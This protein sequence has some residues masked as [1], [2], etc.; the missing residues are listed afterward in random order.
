[1]AKVL[2][3][4]AGITLHTLASTEVECEYKEY[5]FPSFMM[6]KLHF[7]HHVKWPPDLPLCHSLLRSKVGHKCVYM[8]TPIEWEISLMYTWH[9]AWGPWQN[10]LFK[11]GWV[12]PPYLLLYCLFLSLLSLLTLTQSWEQLL[13]SVSIIQR[14]SEGWGLWETGKDGKWARKQMKTDRRRMHKERIKNT[15]SQKSSSRCR[16]GVMRHLVIFTQAY[17]SLTVLSHFSSPT[18]WL[19]QQVRERAFT[20]LHPIRWE[21]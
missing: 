16:W 2:H 19:V 7:L 11:H 3:H 21:E 1:M 15:G 4:I 13:E 12:C 17:R 14:W 10:P 6:V 9:P 20:G 8:L 5:P 18:W